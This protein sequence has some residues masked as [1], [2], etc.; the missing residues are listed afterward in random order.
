MAPYGFDDTSGA[1]LDRRGRWPAAVLAGAA[2][3]LRNRSNSGTACSGRATTVLGD[4]VRA[5]EA[6]PKPAAGT[7]APVN[8]KGGPGAGPVA[9]AGP[10]ANAKIVR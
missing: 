10:L 7:P 3:Q 2:R 4:L 6:Q 9:S 1:F 5:G 8:G